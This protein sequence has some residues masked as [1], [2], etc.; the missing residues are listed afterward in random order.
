[1]RQFEPVGSLFGVLLSGQQP[2]LVPLHP[3]IDFFGP[4]WGAGVGTGFIIQLVP[5]GSI[6]GVLLSGQQP[7]LVP[8]HPPICWG[9]LILGQ[10]IPSKF[11]LELTPS[12][13]QPNAVCEQLPCLLTI[14]VFTNE[15]WFK[16]LYYQ[17]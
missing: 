17:N 15:I 3:P 13:Q 4:G 5:G 10:F 14:V 16:I 6:F 11:T 8:L 9:G 12:G 7:Y 1:M 2:Y